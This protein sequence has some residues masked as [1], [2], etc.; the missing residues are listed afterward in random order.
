MTLHPFCR[1]QHDGHTCH[2]HLGH[3]GPHISRSW[4][5]DLYRCGNKRGCWCDTQEV[6]WYAVVEYG[7]KAV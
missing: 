7:V 1:D 3:A 4:R 6:R 5:A 2:R